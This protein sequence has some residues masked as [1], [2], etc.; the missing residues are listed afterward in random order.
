MFKILD[1]REHFFQWDL[2][3]RL[4][5]SDADVTEVH[6]CNKTGGCSLVCEVYEEDGLRLA[7]VPNILLQDTWKIRVYAYAKNYTKVE[8]AF[9]V[10]PKTKPADYAYTETEVRDWNSL[11]ERVKALEMGNGGGGNVSV[12]L[13]NYYTKDETEAKITEAVDAIDIPEVDLSGYAKTTD[14]PDVSAYQT[15]EQVIALI[16]QNSS[17]T[18]EKE[19][20]VG[21][22]QPTDSNITLWVDTDA[23]ST[24]YT[25]TDI[26]S[27]VGDINTLLDTINGEV[28]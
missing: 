23:E 28:I 4:I 8:V 21:E 12:D 27:L 9:R 16:G 1:G 24:F 26:D 6:F 2:E 25:K 18:G 10:V 7:N 17:G 13:S 11:D 20:Y 3:Q 15:E 19:I 14:I 22:D 5:V